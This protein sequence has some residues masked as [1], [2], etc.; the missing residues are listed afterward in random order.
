LNGSNGI[1]RV[2]A[3]WFR[4]GFGVSDLS[5]LFLDERVE[6][7][8]PLAFE[9]AILVIAVLSRQLEDVRQELPDNT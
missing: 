4:D 6:H 8:G 1:A 2:H 9:V 3:E 7:C 5:K